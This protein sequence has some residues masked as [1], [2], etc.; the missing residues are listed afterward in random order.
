MIMNK[1]KVLHD[2]EHL[3]LKYFLL[4]RLFRFVNLVSTKNKIE[5]IFT[6]TDLINV[7]ILRIFQT[8]FLF[9]LFVHFGGCIWLFII[10]LEG[11]HG[12]FKVHEGGA[13]YSAFLKYI[14]SLE[15]IIF[16]YHFIFHIL[17][18]I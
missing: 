14:I 13:D 1:L 15:V 10:K 3:H 2:I 12:F 4:C 18:L 7:I 9:L 5:K 8:L 16:N 11:D 6:Y 17:Y